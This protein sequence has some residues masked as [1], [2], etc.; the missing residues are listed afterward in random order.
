MEKCWLDLRNDLAAN[1]NGFP[2]CIR[3]L[4]RGGINDLTMNF[5]RITSIVFDCTCNL[6]Q[7]FIERNGIRFAC[8][9]LGFTSR[10]IFSQLLIYHCPM[11]QSLPKS[12]CVAL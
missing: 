1:T 10:S 4:C 12:L 8:N 3:K 5:I 11:S 7:I 2:N 6:C 9:M